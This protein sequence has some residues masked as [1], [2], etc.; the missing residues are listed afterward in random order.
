MYRH[1][2]LSFPKQYSTELY[3]IYIYLLLISRVYSILRFLVS[4]EDGWSWN[5]FPKDIKVHTC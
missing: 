3:D 5:Q 4:I 2:L 1:I